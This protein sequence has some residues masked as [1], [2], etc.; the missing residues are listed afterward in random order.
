[1]V[2]NAA[3][4]QQSNTY[5]Y[6]T[7]KKARK[8]FEVPTYLRGLQRSD[9]ATPPRWTF[10]GLNPRKG[11]IFFIDQ[12]SLMYSGY[13]VFTRVKWLARGV[14]QTPSSSVNAKERVELYLYFRMA[15]YW[16]SFTFAF[17]EK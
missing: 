12:S 13:R 1:M 16:V 2:Y 17:T 3:N 4:S 6:H 8:L 10:R 9:I 14:E 15:C 7:D 5:Q 11:E